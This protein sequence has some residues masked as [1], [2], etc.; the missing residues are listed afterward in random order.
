MSKS[1]KTKQLLL[2]K[3]TYSC[4]FYDV[5]ITQEAIENVKMVV[6]SKG[7]G[8][9]FDQRGL[10]GIFRVLFCSFLIY[11]GYTAVPSV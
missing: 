5:K 9:V 3:G 6:G 10:H 8:K 1:G 4:D 2:F 7:Q 11:V